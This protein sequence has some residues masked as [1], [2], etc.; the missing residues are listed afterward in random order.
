MI[1][2]PYFV[3]INS[4]DRISG[5]DEDFTYNIQFPDG[6]SFDRVVCLNCLIPKS[7]YLVQDSPEERTFQLKED[8]I[9]VSITA[10]VGSYLLS[11]FKKVIGELLTNNSPNGLTYTLAYPSQN[12]PDTGKWTFTQTNGAIQSSIIVNSHFF[13]PFGFFPESQNDFTGTTLA[14]TTVIKLQSEDRLLLH[15][16]CVENGRDSILVS[17]NASSSIN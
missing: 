7:Y 2:N 15:S 16:N 3:Y 12:G 13:E 11:A 9:T 14:S 1:L 6:V 5:T 17:I 4:R 10:P 8:G